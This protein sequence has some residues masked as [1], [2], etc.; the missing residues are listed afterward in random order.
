MQ[1]AYIA[2]SV[3]HKHAVQLLTP[4]L[5]NL[6]LKVFDW[7]KLDSP[8]PGL[9]REE[10]RRWYDTDRKGGDL[11]AFCRAACRQADLTIYYGES[12]QD[13]AV[14][15][16]IASENRRMVYGLRGA[17]ESEGLMLHGAVHRWFDSVS[18]MLVAIG[19]AQLARRL[20]Q[21]GMG[22]LL[23]TRFCAEGLEFRHIFTC[24][25]CGGIRVGEAKLCINADLGK[26]RV[27]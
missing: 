17:L 20:W 18:E 23:H 27:Q 7:T 4:S 9:T 11:F 12:G 2:A 3:Q 24:D 14:E 16:A 15:A 21:S 5:E 25:S 1:T 8:P 26:R 19:R 22:K 13:A 6:G 10:R